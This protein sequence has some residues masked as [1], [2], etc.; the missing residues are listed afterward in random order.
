MSFPRAIRLTLIQFF[1]HTPNN[2]IVAQRLENF[3]V[4]RGHIPIEVIELLSKFERKLVEGINAE[5]RDLSFRFHA[6]IIPHSEPIASP[7]DKVS[8]ISERH[9]C[10]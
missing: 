1:D 7:T 3:I 10:L 8:A 6:P 5:V 2:T 4:F 9:K